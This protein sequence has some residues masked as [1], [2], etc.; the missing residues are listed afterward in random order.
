MIDLE[1]NVKQPTLAEP[2]FLIMYSKPKIGK[3]S[4]L[5]KLP[6]SLLI[7]LENSSDFFEGNG[8][9]IQRKAKELNLHPIKVLR[10]L[11]KKIKEENTKQNKSV[12]DFII[13]DSATILEDYAVLLATQNYRQSTIGKT[14][15]GF[16]VVKELSNGAGYNWMREAFEELYMPFVELAGKCFVLVVHT[17]DSVIN[18]DGKDISTSEL[19]LTG[20]S[21]MITASKADGIGLLYRSKEKPDC[22]ILSFKQDDSNTAI[23][24]RLDHLKNK[25]FEI[26]K[27]EDNKLVSDWELIFPSIK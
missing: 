11:G 17:K 23:G 22:N 5:M 18:K 20:K 15:T 10:E 21:K 12:Y 14:F 16:D 4:L 7:D 9:N 6:N 2:R 26:S 24:C 8:F 1:F 27:I 3:T 25:E 13:M 19:S